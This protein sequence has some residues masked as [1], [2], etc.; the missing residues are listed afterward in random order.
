L[1]SGL[2]RWQLDR[3]G[4]LFF[5]LSPR[6]GVARRG[7]L[8]EGGMQDRRLSASPPPQDSPYL[9]R[10]C[11]GPADDERNYQRPGFMHPPL[12]VRSEDKHAGKICP[13]YRLE[14]S[15]EAGVLNS[16]TSNAGIV[17][18][19]P[20]GP[21]TTRGLNL[22]RAADSVQPE[23][24]RRAFPSPGGASA[25]GVISTSTRHRLNGRS[26]CSPGTR[27]DAC[28]IGVPAVSGVWGVPPV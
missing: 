26:V 13:I 6:V 14:Q 7:V 3:G 19:R 12:R 21:K 5:S 24:A 28:W 22:D 18:L 10:A 8:P 25:Y 20:A 15:S 2:E 11:G 17:V 27:I 1:K 16:P 4:D 23:Q 9:E